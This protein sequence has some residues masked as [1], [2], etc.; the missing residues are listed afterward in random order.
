MT[1]LKWEKKQSLI[2][3]VVLTQLRLTEEQTDLEKQYTTRW[4]EQHN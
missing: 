2:M 3:G 1:K 4:S